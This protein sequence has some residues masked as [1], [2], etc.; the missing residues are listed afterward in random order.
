MTGRRFGR[1]S[2]H[3][4]EA[5]LLYEAGYP[6]RD[7]REQEIARIW[8][9][10][11]EHHRASPT[12]APDNA[13]T[14]D[15]Y[16]EH[17]P[18]R[19]LDAHDGLPGHLPKNKNTDARHR[20]WGAPGRTLAAVLEH[21]Q[22]GNS[23]LLRFPPPPQ[24]RVW[25]PRRM[26]SAASS[27]SSASKGSGRS[28][29]S[30]RPR[31][32]VK[33]EVEEELGVRP[34][35]H[36]GGGGIV[37]HD[38]PVA[39]S[40]RCASSSRRAL[41]SLKKEADRVPPSPEASRQLALRSNEDPEEYPG[42]RMAMRASMEVVQP[43]PLHFALEWSRQDAQAAERRRRMEQAEQ[44]RQLGLVVNVNDEDYVVVPRIGDPGQG[45]SGGTSRYGDPGQGTSGG[46]GLQED[47]GEDS[48]DDEDYTVFYRRLLR[49][50]KFHVFLY[51]L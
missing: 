11:P 15:V 35:K 8:E 16:F 48:D 34:R 51:V 20:W 28:A 47:S 1:R 21:I 18:Q 10:L 6:R 31:S 3:N 13:A 40:G 41:L 19:E 7:E 36:S 5:R 29:S 22:A 14:W 27:S 39:S 4:W 32:T 30:R 45:S 2:L 46:G 26:A 12:W 50:V 43:A 17:R 42:Q 23:P 37:I 24:A 25:A 38:R 33:E 49:L 44:A 9:H